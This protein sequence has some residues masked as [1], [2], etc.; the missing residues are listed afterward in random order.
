[1][2]VCRLLLHQTSFLEGDVG[3]AL[4]HGL[5]TLGGDEY[6]D[7]AAELGVKDGLGLHVDLAAALAGG[8]KLGGADAVGVPASNDRFLA[9]DCADA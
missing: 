2:W 3:T 4:L 8:V 9:R 1:M 6:L 5:E 7:L